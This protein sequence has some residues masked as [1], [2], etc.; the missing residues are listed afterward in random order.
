MRYEKTDRNTE[1]NFAIMQTD[2]KTLKS[3]KETY[4]YYI[5]L[6]KAFEKLNEIV[7]EY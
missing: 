6:E 4:I 5:D 3:N 1:F 7:A 2:E